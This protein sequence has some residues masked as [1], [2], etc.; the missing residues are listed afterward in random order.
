M[1]LSLDELLLLKKIVK[2]HID[3]HFNTAS[4]DFIESDEAALYAK[5]FVEVRERER[6]LVKE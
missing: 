3:C 4:A 2:E 6:Q 5:I 1:T